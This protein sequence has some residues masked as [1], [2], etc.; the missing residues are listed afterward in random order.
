MI[1]LLFSIVFSTIT[2]SFFKL[3]ERYNVD[4]LQAIVF[5]YITCA[6]IGNF[7][8]NNN[9]I[10]A[11]VW[12]LSWFVFAFIL[13]LLFITIFICIGLTAQ[14]ISISAS[15][16]AAKLSVAI[17]VLSAFFLYH[18]TLSIYKII[19]ILLSFVAVWLISKK[20]NQNN[21]NNIL[22]ITLPVIVF[23]GSGMIDTL[24]NY[25][26]NKFIPPATEA[27]IINT[28]FAI[29]FMFGFTY[30][31]WQLA[32]GK[33]VFYLK[34]LMWGLLLGL[35][36]YFSMFFLVK[37]LSFFPATLIFPVNNIGIV[38]ASTTSSILFFKEKQSLTN[39]IGL[40]LAIVSIAV[41]SLF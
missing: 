1:Y 22:L 12:E 7:I 25:M 13:G 36:N 26:Q 5:N 16:V 33:T 18:E 21:S 32:T 15:M 8:L 9:I 41:I 19:G 34:N 23:I 35:P 3:F 30:M 10:E 24:L 37:A 27:L 11:R 31:L 2:V 38:A 17:P 4:T 6:I 20:N 39:K 40:V 14:K 29:A 28:I